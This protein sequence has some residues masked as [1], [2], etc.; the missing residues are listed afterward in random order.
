[1]YRLHDK[2][3]VEHLY[4]HENKTRKNSVNA[5]LLDF[6]SIYYMKLSNKY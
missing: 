5:N 1:M 2:R 3:V 6:L 4:K